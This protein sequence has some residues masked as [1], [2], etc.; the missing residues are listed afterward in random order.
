M[1]ER[2]KGDRVPNVEFVTRLRGGDGRFEWV[3]LSTRV[4]FE[5]KRVVLFATPG[6]FTPTCSIEHL[7]GYEKAYD[8]IL[9]LGVDDVYCLSVNDCFVMRRW[10]LDMGLLEDKRPGTLG[11][12]GVKMIPDGSGHFTRMMGMS[13]SMENKG[14]G[15]RSWRYSMV[16]DDGI[17][18]EIFV[19]PGRVENSKYDPYGVSGVNRM[20]EYLRYHL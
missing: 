8:E 19:E 15:E 4:L 10:G 9:S 20:I 2:K 17:I 1:V 18:E 3:V 6:A 16:V 5:G 13:T 14:F 12:L 11:F 7:P